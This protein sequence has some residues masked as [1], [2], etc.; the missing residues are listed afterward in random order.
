VYEPQALRHLVDTV[1][2]SQLVVGSDYPF[3]MGHNDPHGLLAATPGLSDAER[4]AIL[5]RNASS[6]FGMNV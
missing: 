4:S 6:L 2:A 5:G 1:G 3:D